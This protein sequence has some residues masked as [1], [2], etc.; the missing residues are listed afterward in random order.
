MSRLS[1]G[2]LRNEGGLGG[3]DDGGEAPCWAL[4][5]QG[6]GWLGPE[7]VE[8]VLR[9]S[10][11]RCRCGAGLGLELAIFCGLRPWCTDGFQWLLGGGLGFRAGWRARA[12]LGRRPWRRR[13]C[14]RSGRVSWARLRGFS[15]GLGDFVLDKDLVVVAD[16]VVVV[17]AVVE[18]EAEERAVGDGGG[19]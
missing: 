17:V 2:A 9:G 6:L 18:S 13:G 12:S 1:R 19:S 16:E 7:V 5:P 14:P 10:G 15:R 8:D 4:L 11:S 3:V